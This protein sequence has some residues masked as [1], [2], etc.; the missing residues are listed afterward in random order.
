MGKEK[1]HDVGDGH[2]WMRLGVGDGEC[3]AEVTRNGVDECG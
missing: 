2:I 1:L 3:I